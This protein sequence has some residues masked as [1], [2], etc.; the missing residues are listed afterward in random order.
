MDPAPFIIAF[1]I[2]WI[3]GAILVSYYAAG[4]RLNST[5][6]LLA[7][8][9]LSPAVGFIAAAAAQPKPEIEQT[10]TSPTKKC[11]DCAEM[12]QRDARKCRYC[13]RMFA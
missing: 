9:F 4:K 8:I 2:V 6:Y 1:M 12:I 3:G 13:G 11:P 7:S 5:P 10:L